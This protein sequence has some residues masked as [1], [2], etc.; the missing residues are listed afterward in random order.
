MKRL[1]SAEDVYKA[2]NAGQDLFV[3]KY[4]LITPQAKDIAKEQGV[5][6]VEHYVESKVCVEDKVCKSV[7]I[8]PAS[9]CVCE[10][11]CSEALD[12]EEIYHLLKFALEN[13]LLTEDDLKK[14][15]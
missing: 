15:M 3:D 14:M 6:F 8:K 9:K 11:Q 13:K 5:K 1:I 4:T 2:K 12:A 10:C 7:D